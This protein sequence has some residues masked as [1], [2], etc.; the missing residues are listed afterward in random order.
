MNLNLKEV[1]TKIPK[2]KIIMEKT[3]ISSTLLHFPINHTFDNSVSNVLKL[4]A[5]G[6]KRFLTNKVDRSV[7]GLVAQQQCVGPIHTPISNYALYALSYFNKCGAVTTIGEKPIIG[8][9]NPNKMVRMA[10][11]EMLTNMMGCCIT[12][13]NDIKCSGN[14]MWPAQ[15]PKEKYHLYKAVRSLS[16]LLCKLKIA[17]DGGKDSLFMTTKKTKGPRQ[18]VMSGYCSVDNIYKKVTPEFKDVGNTLFYIDFSKGKRR[19]GGSALAQTFNQIGTNPPDLDNYKVFKKVFNA[20]Q[21]LIKKNLILSCHDISDGGLITTI[22]EMATAG[23]IGCLLRI[24]EDDIFS[25]FF[26][27]ELGIV[28]ECSKK[29]DDYVYEY[30]NKI[31]PVYKLGYT[32]LQKNHNYT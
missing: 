4:L 23:N 1:L 26:A 29:H 15:S 3:F 7:G 9:I 6:S 18:L 30:L 8:L 31:I 27:E 11:G 2:Q 12:R 22:I 20:I 21:K 5:V 25:F 24:K 32:I 17:I 10:V 14:W 28:I 16:S 19:L 13:F